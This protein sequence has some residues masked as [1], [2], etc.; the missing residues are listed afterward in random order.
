[1]L[2]ETMLSA[3]R[4]ELGDMAQSIWTIDDELSRGIEKTISLMSRFIQNRKIIETTIVREITDETLTISSGSGTLAYKPIKVG[5]LS[6]PDKTL[7]TDYRVNYLTGVVTEI[8]TGLPDTDYTVSYELDPNM[9]DISSLLTSFV[10]IERVEYPAGQSPATLVTF[11]KFGDFLAFRGNTT[12]VED[13]HLRIIYLDKWTAPTSSEAGDYPEHLDNIIIIGAAG[14]ALIFKAE[15]Y[16]HDAHA[17]VDSAVTALGNISAVTMPT[18]PTL[19]TYLG[20]ADTALDAAIARFEAAVTTLGSMDTP[21]TTDADAALDS[22]ISELAD[23]FT[24]YLDI[25]DDLINQGTRGES[26]G[27]VYGSYAGY[28]AG[29][30]N[31]YISVAQQRIAMA[32]AYE[33]DA[34]R[35]T[36]IG[37][38]YVNEAIQRLAIAA[39]LVDLFENEIGLA[40]TEV[41]YYNAQIAQANQYLNAATQHLTVAGRYLASGQAKINEFL[42]AFGVKP[43]F[44]TQKSSSEQRD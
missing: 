35:D 42:A 15:E 34:A 39:R 2:K 29:L 30:V 19:T 24:A 27:A 37:N 36:T 22:A 16:M 12:L 25:G 33:Q 20:D 4:A 13:Y 6:I 1:M 17:A 44:P 26:V 18:A 40:D 31:S 28:A 5:S 10:K 38:S 9:L 32:L 3:M 43:E 14:Q 8:G 21:L 41:D 23:A 7:D 11:D